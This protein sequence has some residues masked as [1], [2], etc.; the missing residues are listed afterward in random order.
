MKIFV[1]GATGFIGSAV[2]DELLRRGYTVSGLARSDSSAQ[3]LTAKGV[4]VLR[5]TLT[6]FDVLAKGAKESDGVIHLGFTNN[7]N[8]MAGAVEQDVN[9]VSAMADVLVGT[10]KPFVNTSGTLM[11]AYQGRMA[12]E[13]DEGDDNQLRTRSEKKILSYVDKGVRATAVR[14]SPTVH[15]ATRQGI[16][17]IVSQIAIKNGVAAYI[18]DGTNEWPSVH[19]LDAAELF[20]EAMEKGTAGSIYNA[21]AE[22]AI[23][24]KDI[25]A[26]ISQSV[27]I[28]LKSV[29]ADE[30]ADYAGP[31]FG[32]TMQINNPT[33]SAKTQKELGWTPSH[34]GLLAD[35]A[36][37]LSD[38]ANVEYLKNN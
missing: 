23:P 13:D 14:L 19:R 15:D 9:A 36:T 38:P 11:V 33:S 35:M 7:F 8:D 26:T 30:A 22:E 12:T 29:P 21:A 32:A 28:P 24:F 5:G 18:G 1:T 10:D 4:E 34:P 3:K 31:Y 6:D 25:A 16:A 37:F 2:V 27:D 20:V 17:T